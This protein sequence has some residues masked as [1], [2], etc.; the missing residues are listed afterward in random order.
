MKD[1]R[2]Y[3]VTV[4]IAVL[5]AVFVFSSID[6]VYPNPYMDND[7]YNDI[8][9]L[10]PN[11][12]DAEMNAYNQET[13]ECFDKLEQERDVY[14]LVKFIISAIVGLA[15]VVAG[16]Y[17]RP[18]QDIGLSIASGFLLGGLF[19]LFFGTIDGWS[20]LDRFVRPIVMLIEIIIV[21]WVAYTKMKK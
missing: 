2:K 17:I 3:I 11:A 7:C 13:K 6:A 18:K 5:F 1:F 21:I 19:V 16:M 8:R 4:V 15:A 20:S 10:S 9:A 12:T 14:G